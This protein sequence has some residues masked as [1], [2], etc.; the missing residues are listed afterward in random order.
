MNC[1]G[2]LCCKVYQAQEQKQLGCFSDIEVGSNVPSLE[3][4]TVYRQPKIDDMDGTHCYNRC[5]RIFI[6]D[7]YH[8]SQQN[9]FDAADK[10]EI[11]GDSLEVSSQ[12]IDCGG[13]GVIPHPLR[14]DHL[15]L[16]LQEQE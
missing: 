4:L 2:I 14:L 5:Q 13:E 8:H 7:S 11:L 6:E 16:G 3:G 12:Q 15:L 10:P 1:L 9:L